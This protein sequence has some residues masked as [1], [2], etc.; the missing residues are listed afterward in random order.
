MGWE[1]YLEIVHPKNQLIFR[2]YKEPLQLNKKI[3]QFKNKQSTWI[4]ISPNKATQVAKK[5]MKRCSI[6]LIIS[7]MQIKA[8]MIY[9]LTPIK[10][11]IIYRYI[12]DR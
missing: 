4:D 11:A 10:M 7:G 1:K 3:T 2:I 6:S 5:Y 8:T 12:D 9:N